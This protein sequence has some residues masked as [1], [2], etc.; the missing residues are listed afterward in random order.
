MIPA[1]IATTAVALALTLAFD[2]TNQRLGEWVA[3]P[4]ASAGFIAVALL[5][6]AADS[7]YGLAILAALALSFV[8][9]VALIPRRRN[10]P[11][12]VGLGA[13]LLGHVAFA[14]AFVIRGV[15]ATYCAA[16]AAAAVLSAVWVGRWLLPNVKGGM[17]RP[18]IAYIV[19]I[20][21]MVA[22]SIGVLGGPAPHPLFPAAAFVFWLSDLCVARNRFVSPGFMNR[23]VGL[24]LYYAAQ[25][26]F[27][28]TPGL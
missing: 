9:D 2:Q 21:A 26:A 20:T 23:L 24:P 27:A 4:L 14:V 12:L 28:L 5:S 13:F 7:P 3:K 19:V 8:G 17:R 10:G 18:V 25:V 1:V 11:F 16:G 6:D 15:G 22:L